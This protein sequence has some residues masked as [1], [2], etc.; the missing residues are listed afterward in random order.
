MLPA[1]VRRR[2]LELRRLA[3]LNAGLGRCRA[4]SESRCHERGGERFGNAT[5]LHG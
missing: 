3:R 2:I 5:D 1:G 4:D